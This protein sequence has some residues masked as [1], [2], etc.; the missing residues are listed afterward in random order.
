MDINNLTIVKEI[1]DIPRTLSSVKN[2]YDKIEKLA[3]NI[4]REEVYEF[5]YTGCGSSYYAAIKSSYPLLSSST[6]ILALPASEALWITSRKHREKSARRVIMVLSRSGETAEIKALITNA[7]SDKS[8][9]VVGFTCNPGSFLASSSDYAIAIEGCMEESVYMTKSFVAL[10]LLGTIFSAR[11]MEYLGYEKS[12][13][14]LEDELE[15]LI[16]ASKT[17]VSDFNTPMQLSNIL[18][19]KYP[20]VIL[21]TED[22]YPVALEAALK[23]IEVSYT[24]AIALHALEFRHGYT[25]LLEYPNLSLIILSNTNSI[26]YPYVERLY[27]E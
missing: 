1:Q 9:I 22:L 3:M 11:L 8:N 25:G 26:S 7:K 13:N 20:V 16:E 24:M 23:F 10:S 21:G 5:I 27:T 6:K 19:N 17:L 2:L 15:A 12:M 14:E 4:S 18:I